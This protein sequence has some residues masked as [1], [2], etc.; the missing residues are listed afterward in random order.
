M[1]YSHYFYKVNKKDVDKV[2]DL[3]YEELLKVVKEDYPKVDLEHEDAEDEEPYFYFNDEHFL[4]KEEIFEFGKLYFEDTDA[5]IYA[6]GVPL[7]SK[8]EVQERFSD[9]VPYIVGKEAVLEAIKIYKDKV[10]KYYDGLMKDTEDEFT[11]KV[12]TAS[13]KQKEHFKDMK[14]WLTYL[15]DTDLD[16]KYT[17]THSWLYEH[18]IFNLI[19]ILKTI[20]WENE[21]LLFYG[22]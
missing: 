2:K 14:M 19:H 22:W 1:G 8:K 12:L 15:E 18:S 21:E 10:I 11:G 5:R 4:N 20:D 13:D 7:F 16:N 17:V 6:T 9:Y 3:T